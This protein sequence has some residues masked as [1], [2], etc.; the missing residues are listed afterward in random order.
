M[1][2]LE[3]AARELI[4][5]ADTARAAVWDS[6]YGKGISVEYARAVEAEVSAAIAACRAA[7]QQE[8][9]P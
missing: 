4:K 2:P 3:Q 1:T 8:S 6:Y 9:K 7:E 5:A